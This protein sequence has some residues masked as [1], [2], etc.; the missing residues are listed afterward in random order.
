MLR[1]VLIS[2]LLLCSVAAHAAPE[3]RRLALLAGG[4]GEDA[5]K[6]FFVADLSDLKKA[7]TARGWDVSVVAGAGKA[8]H[9]ALEA[10]AQKVLSRAR[11]GDEVLLLFHSHGQPAERGWGQK[12]HS[13]SSDDSDPSGAQ[14]GFDLDRLERSF[15]LARQRGL[16]VGF[17][18]LSC[19]SGASQ[20]LEGPAC[21]VT[22]AS[23]RYVSLCSGRPEEKHFSSRFFKLPAPGTPASL[24]SQFLDARR[25]DVGSVN[26]PA[27]SS[28]TNP[29][30]ELWEDFLEKVDPL[31][32][33]DE[34]Y[35]LRA[36]REPFN[37]R[38]LLASVKSQP[39]L[40]AA[41]EHAVSV[42][43]ELQERI[44]E[45]ARDYDAA[46]LNIELPGG[47]HLSISP[48]AL[49]D[50][51]DQS[52]LKDPDLDGWTDVQRRRLDEIRPLRSKIEAQFREP[53]SKFRKSREEFDRLT[54]E[55]AA[56]AGA[57]LTLERKAYDLSS[58]PLRHDCADFA[59]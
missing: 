40:P 6:N 20:S 48:A 4:S 29:Q 59:L 14:P 17:V 19:Y 50:L 33:S 45:L 15:A 53:V 5:P 13:I 32:V 51:L 12:S 8:T 46:N 30:R 38:G 24:E 3:G 9:S 55:L 39:T 41:I 22:L 35:E 28:R 10:A 23:S 7:L 43:K 21:T 2:G 58:T 42:R 11:P 47:A 16:R 56:S 49:S 37:P 52:A 26:L 54:E 57:A 18:D 36:G 25:A 1:V 34:L 44:P 27:I 31:D